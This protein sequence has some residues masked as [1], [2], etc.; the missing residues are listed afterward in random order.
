LA[1]SESHAGAE[2]QIDKPHQADLDRCVHCGLCLN[3]CPT[4]RELGVEMDSPRGRI[5][6]MVQVAEGQPIGDSYREHIDLC[7]AC[8]G[9]ESACPS[10]VQYGRLVEAARA[11]IEA[12][13]RRPWLTRMLRDFVFRKLLPSPM[14]LTA[15]GAMLYVYQISGLQKVLR[16][17]GVM[18]LLG[19]LG[20]REA[21]APSAQIPFFF[22]NIG[23]TF[24]AEGPAKFRVAMMAGC[25]ANISFARLNEATVRVLQKNGCDVVI[26]AGQT[27]C[28][29]LH[30]HAGIRDQARKLARQ[31]IDA[32]LSLEESGFDA[33]LTNAAGCGSTLKEYDELFEHEPQYL[34]K[35]RKFKSLMK[36]VT[37]FLASIELNRE[38]TPVEGTVTYQ[39]SCHLAHGQKIRKAPRDL[40][41]A[42]PG[43][44]F[45]EM[46]LSDICCGSA[47]IYNVLHTDLSMK[48]LEKK[49]DNVTLARA[50]IVATANPGCMLQLEAGVRKWGHGERVVHVVELL[51]EAYRGF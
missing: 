45:T 28:G 42:I 39:D 26:P 7:L 24:P 32:V 27:C 10:G 49:M 5:Y 6:Q 16:A 20:D 38:M 36:D 23:Q 48:I 13:T 46:P 34:E 22:R 40:L 25:I 43:L 51:D 17:A 9:C 31:N 37:E 1:G 50:G 3:A 8:R 15:A 44:K 41:R 11:E 29:A 19:S 14:L 4:Y 12:N 35:A 33:I 47:G 30:V 18:R 2:N 21:L